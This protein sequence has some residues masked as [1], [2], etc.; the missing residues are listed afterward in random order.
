EL[1]CPVACLKEYEKRTKMFRPS[2]SK[3]PN[4]LFL[5]LNKPHKP[6]TSS[7]LSHW[8]KV[9]LLE[10]GI[11]NNVFKAHSARG[12]STSAAARAG[13]SLPEIIKLGDR[14]KDSTFKRFYYRP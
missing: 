2:S 4:K 14:T 5:S 10:A 7:T 6:I 3:E 11:E 12:A 9:C 8:V 13:I 1:L